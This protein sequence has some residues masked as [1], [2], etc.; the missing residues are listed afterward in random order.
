[1]LWP[2]AFSLSPISFMSQ[3]NFYSQVYAVVRLIPRGKVTSYGRIAR[4]LGRNR[5]ARAVGYALNNLPNARRDPDF[6]HVPW[7]RV[8][9]HVGRISIANREDS[10]NEQGF[11][12]REEGIEIGE[13]LHIVDFKSV[14]WDGLTLAEIDAILTDD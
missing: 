6:E 11:L 1:M 13:D 10:A 7:Q 2:L 4:M 12:L 3:A 9:N 8:V 5:A 14:L